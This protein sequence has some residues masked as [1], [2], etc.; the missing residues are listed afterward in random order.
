MPLQMVAK[1]VK[2][3]ENN[4]PPNFDN[5]PMPRLPGANASNSVVIA[6]GSKIDCGTATRTPLAVDGRVLSADAIALQVWE[7]TGAPYN[8]VAWTG[9]SAIEINFVVAKG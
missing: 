8:V 2:Y 1:K 5:E 4:L 3:D 7:A 6:S 9:N